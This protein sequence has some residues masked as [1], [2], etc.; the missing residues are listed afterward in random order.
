MHE[1]AKKMARIKLYL[2]FW[3]V[4]IRHDHEFVIYGEGKNAKEKDVIERNTLLTVGR[5]H[6]GQRIYECGS[7]KD[8]A[9]RELEVV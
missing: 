3:V 8:T 6:A 5:R 4:V 9:G 7:R 2:V 1:S